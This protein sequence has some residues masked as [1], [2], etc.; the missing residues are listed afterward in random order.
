MRV[1]RVVEHIDERVQIQRAKEVRYIDPKNVLV[2]ASPGMFCECFL[3]R[4]PTSTCRQ[5]HACAVWLAKLVA[6]RS[7]VV[8]LVS[9]NGRSLIR[10]R[11]IKQAV[12][13]QQDTS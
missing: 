1:S 11:L 10:E 8:S 6:E 12:M 3:Q 7:S 9:D 4:A 13:R 5:E 2:S